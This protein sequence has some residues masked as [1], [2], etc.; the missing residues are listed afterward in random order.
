VTQQAEPKAFLTGIRLLMI[1][2]EPREGTEYGLR[3]A[4]AAMA[5]SGQIEAFA[6]VA[7]RAVAS[8]SG[9]QAALGAIDKATRQVKPTIVLVLSPSGLPASGQWVRDYRKQLGDTTVLYWEGDPWHPLLKRPTRG[10]RAWATSADIVFSV[11]REPQST[12]LRSIGARDVRFIP[13]TYCHVQFARAEVPKAH[14]GREPDFDVVLIGSRLARWGR[15]SRVLGA[16]QRARLVARMQDDP[17]IRLALYGNGWSG[18]GWLGT[19]PYNEQIEALR[20]GR[21]SVN[22]DHFPAHSSYAS[23]R[24]AISLLAGRPHVTTLHP[25]MGW[26]P[27]SVG[28]FLEPDPVALLERSRALLAE[29]PERLLTMGAAAHSW[30][31][32]RLSDRQAAAYMLGAVDR[33]FLDTLPTD[34]WDQ[35]GESY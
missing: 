15:V 27:K 19:V 12:L 10:M 33:R 1:T 26:L 8:E 18:R 14:P 2:N 29:D 23:D 32:N 13:H 34:P 3:A 30:V 17:R 25:D 21:I 9:I 28:L 6:A 4:Y 16:V 24:L 35:F 20:G 11:A 22:W 31:V 5:D 7:P